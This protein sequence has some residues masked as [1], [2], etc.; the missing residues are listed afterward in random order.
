MV[1]LFDKIYT[2]A[3][4]CDINTLNKIGEFATNEELDSITKFVFYGE[5]EEESKLIIKKYKNEE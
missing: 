2:K 3:L 1:S 5:Q 4:D